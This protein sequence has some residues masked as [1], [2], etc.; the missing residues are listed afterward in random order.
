[1]LKKKLLSPTTCALAK[2][3]CEHYSTW[4]REAAEKAGIRS[5][6]NA[7]DLEFRR[8][9]RGVDANSNLVTDVKKIIGTVIDAMDSAGRW[10]QAE[11]ADIDCLKDKRD[12]SE[13]SSSDSENVESDES[14]H[15]REIRAVKIDFRDV[16]GHEQ[17]IL[18]GS[19]R[20][21]TK[22][23]YTKDSIKSIRLEQMDDTPAG[24]HTNGESKTLGFVLKHHTTKE[25][26]PFQL[27]SS[28]CSFPGFGACGLAN[29]G[30]TCYANSAVQCMSYMPLLRSYLLSN[31]F[32]KF[33]DINKDNPLG[34]GGRLLEEFASLQQLMWSAKLG[35]RTPTKF[36]AQLARAL[37]QYAGADQQDAQVSLRKFR[38]GEILVCLI[39][40]SLQHFNMKELLNDLLDA[41]HEDSNKVA[42]KPYVEALEDEWVESR[43]LS[44][45]GEESWRR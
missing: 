26:T 23:R 3:K 37:Q 24:K 18:I 33:G 44:K 30:N 2:H 27:S 6:D 22:G 42:K 21:A 35:V 31:Q 13:D 11:I 29:M 15:P 12:Y 28:V 25:P 40:Y 38:F 8:T 34:T 41:L 9:L 39:F 1:M 36:R 14:R 4:P 17:W 43:T 5:R 10:Y 32:K 20:L 19:D 7:E 45:V 16:G